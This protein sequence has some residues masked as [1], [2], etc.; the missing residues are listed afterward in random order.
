[1]DIQDNIQRSLCVTAIAFLLYRTDAIIQY[2]KLFRLSK[3]KAWKNFQCY[4]IGRNNFFYSMSPLEYAKEFYADNFLTSLAGCPFCLGFWL[5]LAVCKFDL[6]ASLCC[7]CVYIVL[8]K[9]IN[10]I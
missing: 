6:M 7:Y 4:Y 10:K 5:S 9:L 2:A 1:M 8:Y 3:F